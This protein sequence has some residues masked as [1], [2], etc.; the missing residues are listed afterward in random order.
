MRLLGVSAAATAA[1]GHHRGHDTHE[2]VDKF[3]EGLMQTID[4]QHAD[5]VANED[6]SSNAFARFKVR[7]MMKL[8]VPNDGLRY[9]RW[10]MG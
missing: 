6:D 7:R 8:A 4:A 3:A 2:S 10:H 9:L 5:D 1:S